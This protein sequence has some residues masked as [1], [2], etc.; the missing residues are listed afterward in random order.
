M[1]SEQSEKRIKVRKAAHRYEDWLTKN[2]EWFRQV[3]MANLGVLVPIPGAE[4]LARKADLRGKSKHQQQV[5]L[6]AAKVLKDPERGLKYLKIQFLL[7]EMGIRK[8]SA[9]MILRVLDVIEGG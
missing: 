7:V 5:M 2:S 1:S 8:P 4:N 6:E 9:D 3:E